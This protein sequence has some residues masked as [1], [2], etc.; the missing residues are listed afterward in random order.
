MTS[1][2]TTYLV[3]I[4]LFTLDHE[5]SLLFMTMENA[6]RD[7]LKITNIFLVNILCFVTQTKDI[8]QKRFF[9]HLNL[10]ID[11]HEFN[12]N[13]IFNSCINAMPQQ[14]LL[15]NKFHCKK[16][17]ESVSDEN[18]IPFDQSRSRNHFH[19]RTSSLDYVWVLLLSFY[20]KKKQTKLERPKVEL[21]CIANICCEN[22]F[23]L[24]S[25]GDILLAIFVI[26][27]PMLN[28]EKRFLILIW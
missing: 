13:K 1:T 28:V 8:A 26:M 17:Y 27:I 2:R 15:F 11:R 23:V 18:F 12:R 10:A 20:T 22:S 24:H 9:L 5:H 14:H 16:I 4:I 6:Y 21:F 25:N 19:I 7:H 3:Y